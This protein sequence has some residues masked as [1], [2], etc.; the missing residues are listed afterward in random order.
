VPI[1]ARGRL[2]RLHIALVFA[3]QQCSIERLDCFS[4]QV[5]L[6]THTLTKIKFRE[7]F[8]ATLTPFGSLIRIDPAKVSSG[9]C[10]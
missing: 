3:A 4:S 10:V 6:S 1:V 7:A 9:A 2:L 5:R 8:S